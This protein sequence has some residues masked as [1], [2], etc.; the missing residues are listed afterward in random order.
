MS[1]D[2]VL[3][4]EKNQ[5]MGQIAIAQ[6]VIEHIV[7]LTIREDANI[8]VDSKK[9]IDIENDEG[10][11]SVHL[12]LRV[13]YGQDVDEVCL[14]FQEQLQRNLDLMIDYKDTE[15]NIAVVGFKFD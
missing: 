3:I 6:S 5:G 10:N 14:D 8:F 11:L 2:Y 4:Q 12:E 13:Q 9:A 7:G 1:S 15:I